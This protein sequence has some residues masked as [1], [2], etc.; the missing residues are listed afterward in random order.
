MSQTGTD[1]DAVLEIALSD[2]LKVD[3]LTAGNSTLSTD[4]LRVKDAAGNTTALGNNGLSFTNAAG[5]ATG[6]SISMSGLDAGNKVI[7]NVV[8]GAITSTSK[9]AV[10]G[11]QL[12]NLM[13]TAVTTVQNA[14]G[15]DNGNSAESWRHNGQ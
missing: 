8:A 13:G 1:Q 11:S 9:E 6:P 5:T 12:G 10:N 3:S 15:K 4:G 2:N 14:D 7:S